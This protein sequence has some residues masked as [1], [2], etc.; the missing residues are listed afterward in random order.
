MGDNRDQDTREMATFQIKCPVVGCDYETIESSEAIIAA[1][2]MNAHTTTHAQPPATS[3]R[4]PSSNANAKVEKLKRPTISTAGTSEEWEYFLTRWG[5]YR[6]GTKL[7]GSD[8]VTQ[9]LE[10]CDEGLR[11]D[12][13]SAAGRSLV[14]EAESDVLEAMKALAVRGENAMVARA[15]LANMRQGREEP[16][17]SFH[18]RIKA[19][20]NTCKYV[21]KCT[22]G[23][24]VNFTEEILR[25]VMARGIADQDIQLDLLSDQRQDMS[26][27]DMMRFIEAKESGKRSASRLLDTHSVEAVSST[28]RRGKRRDIQSQNEVQRSDARSDA[29]DTRHANA[30]C[31]YCGEKG[32]GKNPSW[33]IRRME[34]PAYGKRC[35]S[36]GRDNHIDRVCLGRKPTANSTNANVYEEQTAAFV[37]L[38]TISGPGTADGER[39]L[40][41]DHHIYDNLCDRWLRRSS[42]PQPFLDLDLSIAEEDYRALGFRLGRRAKTVTLPAMADT[43]CQSCLVGIDVVERMG[44]S[45]ADLL[46][47]SMRMKAANKQDIRILGAVIIR[48]SGTKENS[49]RVESRQVAYVTDS[50]DRVFLSRAACVDLGLV[51]KDFP[52]VGEMSNTAAADTST[53]NGIV[54]QCAG[55]GRTAP[56]PKP[57][58]LPM[59]A[60]AGNREALQR[61]LIELYASSTFNTCTHQPLPMM[62]GPPMRLMVDPS[63]HPVAH[64]TPIPVPLYWQ[65]AVKT[66]LDQDVEMGV[67]EPVP[68]GEP[69]TWCHRMVICAKK[70]GKPRRT[71]DFQALNAHATRETHH[72]QSPFHQARC[73]PPGK[74][75]TVFDAWNGYHSVPLHE[76]DRHLTT[77]ITPWGR[78]RYRVAPQGYAA[79][80]DGYSRR[81]DEIVSDIPN[82]TKC[83]DDTLLWSDS[84][85]DSFHQA[86]HWLDTCGRNGITLNPDKFVFGS[87]E[88]E[89]AGFTITEDSVRPCARYLQ[90]IR[91]FPRPQNITD[92]RSWFGLVNQVSYAFSMADHMLPFRQ[93]LKPGGNFEWT[94]VLDDAFKASKEAIVREIEHGVRIFDKTKPTCLATDWSKD[95]I[96]FW[97]FQK[98]CQ[99]PT[100]EP[101]CCRDGWK[102]ALV[103][104]RFTHPAE[105]RYAAVEGEALAV[106]DALDKARFFVLGCS[107]LIVA[108]DHKPL[109]KIFS[110][111]SLDDIPNPRL[112]NLKEKTLRYRFRI[113]HVAG[114]RNKAADAISRHPSGTARPVKL[115]LPDD[116][117]S[118]REDTPLSIH[119]DILAWM[120]MAESDAD[121]SATPQTKLATLDSLRAVTWDRVRE[122]TASDEAA[123][124]LTR[125]IEDGFPPSRD[126]I[127]ADLRAYYQLRDDLSASD[128]VALYKDRVII[129][130]SLRQEVLAALHSAHQGV[131]MMTA[132][133]EASVF[134]PGITA[135]I[136][137]VRN[138]CEHCHRMAPS[139]PSA[140]PV[141][142]IMPVYPFQAICADF[143]THKGTH[144]LVIVDRYSNWPIISRSPGGAKGLI[145]NLRLAFVTYGTPEE[146]ASDGGPEFTATDTRAFLR[147]WGV[148]HRLSSVAFPHSNCRAEIG[149]KTM[150]RLITDNTGQDGDLNTD[151]V[152]RAVL[153]YRNT[154]DPATKVS[155]AMCVF[156]RPIRDFIPVL[157]GKYQPHTTWR[158]TLTAR[159]DALRK[160]HVRMTDTWTEHTRRLPPLRVGDHVRIQNQTGP[161]PTKWDRTGTI[162]EVRQFDQYVV[163]VDGSGRVTLRNR[164]F[165][166]KFVPVMH[167]EPCRTLFDD[168]LQ[169]AIAR[170]APMPAIRPAEPTSPPAVASGRPALATTPAT[171]QAPTTSSDTNRPTPMP[172]SPLP[173]TSSPMTP[174]EPPAPTSPA[175]SPSSP[176]HQPT[177]RPSRNTR[178]PKWHDDFYME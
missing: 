54:T 151:A 59:P 144:Y 102:V 81:Y 127:P 140:P 161:H 23:T 40:N 136:H 30:A 16:V 71:V 163:K 91:D 43:G 166:R 110:D 157:P 35:G 10:C 93:L 95:G 164:K 170:A 116:S 37:A 34:C 134:W 85:E 64:H 74:R 126:K 165:L 98:H 8:I 41:L 174:P 135:D 177:S 148:H 100:A 1:A 67:I 31:K 17:R 104:S 152:Q 26:L 143:F 90:A 121:T 21:K 133:A 87:K 175:R 79:S 168:L 84:I 92:A 111:R 73:V 88:V 72:T 7:E 150:K 15:A 125:L 13:T 96:G 171:P 66:G 142:P 128:G 53:D 80:G 61:Y 27:E 33:R 105:S 103:G 46:P 65:D 137:T 3:N 101:F 57:T 160:R 6:S 82:K 69:V 149:V 158:E 24:N 11:K 18:A 28:Y 5:E 77:F 22:C 129:P 178:P 124:T 167:P 25:D 75:K 99:C 4:A 83:I 141:P 62:S 139:Q 14:G 45:T 113:V 173:A 68:V 76:D 70:T 39:T 55:P 162:I 138:N 78:Y 42:Q 112:R 29:R 89:F 44:L 115:G 130:P 159:E 49:Q 38:C 118:I 147:D 2:L 114:M 94:T 106:A 32:H 47:V 117:A 176:D 169:Q 52:T 60:T 20:A 9:L 155:P 97:L 145:N 120:R 19:Q 154:P 146:L 63:A 119:R 172:P 108:V 48:F 156:G 123:H 50:T 12:L 153:Q 107:D 86:V 56:P 132:R 122:A 36:C 109:L 131:S 51:S 58:T